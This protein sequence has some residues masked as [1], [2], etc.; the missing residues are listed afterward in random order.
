[1]EE[2]NYAMLLSPILFQHNIAEKKNKKKSV[3]GYGS[4]ETNIMQ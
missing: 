1:M 3:T 2:I 4:E